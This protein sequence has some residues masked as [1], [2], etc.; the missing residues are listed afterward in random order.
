MTTPEELAARQRIEIEF[1]RDSALER[2]ESDSVI[3]LINKMA[4]AGVF[5]DL[6]SEFADDFIGPRTS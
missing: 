6:I 4:E 5:V 3:N 2:P 1:W